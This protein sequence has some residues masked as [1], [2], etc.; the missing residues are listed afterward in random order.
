MNLIGRFGSK[1]YVWINYSQYCFF[2]IIDF[3]FMLKNFNNVIFLLLCACRTDCAFIDWNF[4][5]NFSKNLF[6]WSS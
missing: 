1:S 3:T 2:E 5:Y 6:R 4:L